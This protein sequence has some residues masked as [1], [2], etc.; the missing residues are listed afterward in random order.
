MPSSRLITVAALCAAALL[1]G[2]GASVSNSSTTSQ[3]ST[4]TTPGPD[5]FNPQLVPPRAKTTTTTTT[6]R[7]KTKPK[8]RGHRPGKTPKPPT[9]SSGGSPGTGGSA[10]TGSSGGGSR[11]VTI[12]RTITVT[13][14]R[15]IVRA[16]SV[17]SGAH[18][19]S[20][21]GALSFTHF[22]AA[23]GNIG[24]R[25]GGG[26]V[27]CDVGSRVWQSPAK[28][29]DCNLAWGQGLEIG[30][31]GS[32]HFVCAADSALDPTGPVV[33]AGRDDRVGSVTCQVRSF[34]VTCF[35][36]AGHGFFISRT[37]YDTF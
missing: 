25:L 21:Q 8:A 11:T 2:C 36:S 26:A 10:P 29:K 22:A 14:T 18:V 13:K 7:S 27:R 1:S 32:A 5:Q 30:P 23:G 6:T 4:S 33:P 31:S 17:P 20:P 9:S 16:P 12:T 35:D 34:G 19:P 28:P 37:G 24:C 3:T 15:T